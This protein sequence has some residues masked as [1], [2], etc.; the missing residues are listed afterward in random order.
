M[1]TTFNPL[2]SSISNLTQST[3]AAAPAGTT[4]D[5]ATAF[6]DIFTQALG[7][8]EATDDADQVSTLELL[9]GQSDSMSGLM[10]DAQK[11]ELSLNLALQLRNKALDAYKE[12]MSMQV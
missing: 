7:A 8:A 2:A 11:A 1:S 4:N 6:S 9:S 10:L 12:I 3:A 5:L